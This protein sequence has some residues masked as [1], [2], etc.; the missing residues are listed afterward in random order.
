MPSSVL[1]IGA[2]PDGAVRSLLRAGAEI[3]CV[4]SVKHAAG[5]P[6]GI[7]AVPVHDPADVEDVLLG[8]GRHGIDLTEFDVVT[9]ALEYGLVAA[10]V[11]GTL[12]GTTSVLPVSTAVR[13]R[14][15]IVQKRVVR[16][17]RVLVAA[18]TTAA[19]EQEATAAV[20][21]VGGP[22]VVVKP[23][24]GAGARETVR[25]ADDDALTH[26]AGR[27]RP[28]PWTVEAFVDGVEHHLDGVVREGRVVLLTVSR[29]LSNM[30]D[31]PAGGMNGSVLLRPADE[32]GLYQA[33]QQ[34]VSRSLTA[35]EHTTGVFHLEAFQ[36]PDGQLVF[37][38][39]GGR[40][41]GKR[42]DEMIR[43]AT[44]V[45][46]HEEWAAA[47]LGL[48]T[49]AGAAVVREDAAFGNLDLLA[50]PGRIVSLPGLDDLAR[51]PGVVHAE[52]KLRPGSTM[53][54][55]EDTNTRVGRVVVSGRNVAEVEQ[56]LS[57]AAAWLWAQ[58]RSGSSQE[59]S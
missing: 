9:S 46:L 56:H 13:L 41:A 6:P 27:A 22:P 40:V 26:W 5:L 53:T 2:K 57:E 35:M 17:A 34:L 55:F 33:A 20:K 48:P 15:K 37:G 24:H 29:Y 8:L 54:S 19:D 14:D 3:T 16:R 7:R 25:L 10:S 52:Y 42:I 44:G 59:L 4:A 49:G 21:A 1:L 23:P 30:I 18:N 50:P 39:C 58:A 51:R 28:G 11:I 12:A 36:R 43:L 47:V 38:E 31:V 45:D 32:P